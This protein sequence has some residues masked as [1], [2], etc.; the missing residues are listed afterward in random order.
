MHAVEELYF[1]RRYDEA[2]AFVRKVLGDRG[3]GVDMAGGLDDESRALLRTYEGKCIDKMAG[4][5][6]KA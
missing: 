4:Q 5:A 3:D 2:V 6:Q 1:Y